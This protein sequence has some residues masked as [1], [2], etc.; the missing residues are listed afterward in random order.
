MGWLV[1]AWDGIKLKA[2]Y[3][4][5]DNSM[6]LIFQ[7]HFWNISIINTIRCIIAKLQFIVQQKTHSDTSEF[8]F[9]LFIIKIMNHQKDGWRSLWC[10]SIIRR[11]LHHTHRMRNHN[12]MAVHHMKFVHYMSM[13]ISWLSNREWFR[14]IFQKNHDIFH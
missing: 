9:W 1:G 8:C 2:Q 3:L 13:C 4:N 6:I 10:A 14:E 12:R 7:Y 5:S 11:I